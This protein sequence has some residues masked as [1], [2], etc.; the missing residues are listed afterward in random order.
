MNFIQTI[1]GG[2]LQLCRLTG[3]IALG[4]FLG[5]QS[6]PSPVESPLDTEVD[7]RPIDELLLFF[8]NKFPN[9]DWAPK[10]LQFEDVYFK[11]SDGTMLHGWY[12]PCEHAQAT[13][14]MS[15]GN[16]GHIADRSSWLAHLQQ[17]VKVAVF[18]YDYRGYGRSE[19][20]P[21]V[22]G[23]IQDAQAAREKLCE[24]ADLKSDQIV[25]MGESLGGAISVQLAAASPAKALILQSTF[26]SLQEVAKIHYP[27]LS[28]LVSKN[29][30]NSVD[31][32]VEHKA[33]FCKATVT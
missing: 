25:L 17:Q 31:K 29:K 33:H 5:C 22:E 11:S 8:P 1:D 18:A 26:S 21:S 2:W 13:V 7:V 19:G 20:K 30:L 23:A 24:L 10:N 27:R 14:L 4:M 15:H 3:T 6:P 28:W 32:I 9:G 12:C 16:A